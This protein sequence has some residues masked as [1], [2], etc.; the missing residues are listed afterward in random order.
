MVSQSHA[1]CL[2]TKL[3]K[4]THTKSFTHHIDFNLL[5]VKI[6]TTCFDVHGHRGV[7]KI[8]NEETAVLMYRGFGRTAVSSFIIYKNLMTTK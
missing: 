3:T 7:F 1:A 4:V 5:R 6:K 2:S 8:I